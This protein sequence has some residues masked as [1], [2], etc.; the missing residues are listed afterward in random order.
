MTICPFKT[1]WGKHEPYPV[2]SRCTQ[3]IECRKMNKSGK[4]FQML[5][6]AQTSDYSQFLTL[7]FDP[8]H[9]ANPEF[10]IKHQMHWQQFIKRLR[11]NYKK[12]K[13]PG[14]PPIRYFRVGEH[15]D[16]NKRWHYHIIFFNLPYELLKEDW[17]KLWKMGFIK[18]KDVN[19]KTISYVANY[20]SVSKY[21]ERENNYHPHQY[22]EH[23][24]SDGLGQEGVRQIAEKIYKNGAKLKNYR[25][26]QNPDGDDREQRPHTMSFDGITYIPTKTVMNKFVE[27]FEK[28]QGYKIP[29]DEWYDYNQALKNRRAELADLDRVRKKYTITVQKH[30]L[31]MQ[32]GVY[33]AAKKAPPSEKFASN[34][35]LSEEDKIKI[36]STKSLQDIWTTRSDPPGIYNSS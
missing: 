20:T 4:V 22:T 19:I 32:D 7:T 23:S 21:K 5:M 24:C 17:E 34:P 11:K 26:P 16:K 29:V 35:Y 12:Y 28:L 6:E 33:K 27:H 31:R 8:I 1:C 2:W 14:D 25:T 13:L 30:K 3:C 15:G 10:D 36:Q 9:E 18:K